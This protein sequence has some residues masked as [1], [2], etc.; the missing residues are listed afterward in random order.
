MSEREALALCRASVSGGSYVLAE[1][2]RARLGAA[3][4]TPADVKHALETAKR[5]SPDAAI[6]A[7]V[8]TW[9]ARGSSVDGAE[10]MLTVAFDGDVVMVL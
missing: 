8:T 3:G 4:L 10:V 7:R 5:C 6:S 1:A 2:A 9:K